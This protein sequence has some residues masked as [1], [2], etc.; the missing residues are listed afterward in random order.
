MTDQDIA[1]RKAKA[2]AWFTQ[3]QDDVIA[4]F[5]KLEDEA[6][7]PLYSGPPGRFEKTPWR[8]GDG[9]EDLGG[10][11]MGLLRGRLFEKVGVHYSEVYGEFSEEFS[12][13]IP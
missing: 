10:G 1:A 2:S 4:V 5:E 11:V 8:R 9:G 12:A 7:P 13:Q 3:L 6:D